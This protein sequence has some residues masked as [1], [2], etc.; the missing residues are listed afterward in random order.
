MKTI[1]VI[2]ATAASEIS[3]FDPVTTRT[4]ETDMWDGLPNGQICE[5]LFH[6]TNLYEG[7]AWDLLQ[8]LPENRTHT[9]LSVGD[10]VVIDGRR[11]RCARVGWE[12]TD[13]FIPG[14][15]FS[16]PREPSEVG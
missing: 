4:I 11:Y 7:P 16:D 1:Q 13:T 10:Y 14:L 2:W 3:A 8:P 6:D 15:C 5:I 12:R 9:S